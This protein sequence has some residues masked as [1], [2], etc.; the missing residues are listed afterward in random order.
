MD[1]NVNVFRLSIRIYEIQVQVKRLQE[2][3][4]KLKS[5]EFLDL[6]TKWSGVRC[7]EIVEIGAS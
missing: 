5:H 4:I 7:F 3:G 2:N 1:S 6:D